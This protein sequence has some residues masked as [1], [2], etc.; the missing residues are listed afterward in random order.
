MTTVRPVRSLWRDV[1]VA[2]RLLLLGDLVSA[3]GVGITQPYLVVFLHTVKGV[4]L[5]TATAMTSL[6]ALASFAGN[7]LSGM[8]ADRTGGHRAMT[9][10]LIST[11]VG[12]VI[13]ATGDGAPVLGVGVTL[14]GFGWSVTLPAY[15]TLIATLVPPAAH[16]RTFTLQYGLFNAG[17]GAGA[18]IGAPIVHQT[19]GAGFTS[20]WWLA[21]A[22]C[23]ASMACVH[24]SR[25][26]TSPPPPIPTA[27]RPAGDH[28]RVLADRTLL[29]ALLAAALTSAAGYGVYESAL[30]ALAVVSGDPGAMSW[31]AVANCA[32]IVAGMPL[33][34]RLTRRL[35]PRGLLVVTAVAWS[36]AWLLCAVQ[37]QWHLL[38]ATVTLALAAALVGIGELF[39]AGALP[40][41]V[42]DLAPDA[43]RGR[44]NAL[45]MMA[46]TSGMWAGPLA[47]AA[48]NAYGLLAA[49]F[50]AAAALLFVAPALLPGRRLDTG[51][52]RG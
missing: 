30:P 52:P 28:R 31:A 26:R 32:A 39:V 5:V 36:A 40:A 44:Y 35:R 49:L 41:T 27:A 29:R 6:P 51:T 48:A 15:S 18:A 21:A 24:L 9:T 37:Y 33:T 46:T 45:L 8:L 2:V 10:G 23:V 4:P 13:V 47:A 16:P 14:V 43:L 1:P 7:W 19:S 42:N 11:I 20:L 12:L 22:T 34:L 38:G 3:A 17:M 50:A 25:T